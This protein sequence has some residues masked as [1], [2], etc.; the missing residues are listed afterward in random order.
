MDDMSFVQTLDAICH[1]EDHI[2]RLLLRQRECTL[3][4]DVVAQVTAR[5]Q[6]GNEHDHVW[7]FE[8][9]NELEQVF[10]L[11][12]SDL[13]EKRW[14]LK[15]SIIVFSVD[16]SQFGF[17]N[18]FDC[19]PDAGVF[20]LREDDI[21]EGTLPQLHRDLVLADAVLEALGF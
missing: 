7:V 4:I 19:V 21:P 9:L 10:I 11:L 5:H 3:A 16:L 6:P 14:L 12:S 8:S 18:D 15:L 17:W 13:L 1:V 2:S 20:M